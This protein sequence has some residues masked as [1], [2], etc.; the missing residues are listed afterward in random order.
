MIFG[1][2]YWICKF[3]DFMFSFDTH[4]LQCNKESTV[5]SVSKHEPTVFQCRSTQF[6]GVTIANWGKYYNS[7][8]EH[9]FI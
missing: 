1:I 3:L 4:V 6:Y 2:L 8:M 5:E 7:K 9:Y